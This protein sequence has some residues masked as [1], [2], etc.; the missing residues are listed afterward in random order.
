MRCGQIVGLE[1]L[2]LESQF[3]LSLVPDGAPGRTRTPDPLIRRHWRAT[4]RVPAMPWPY[5]IVSRH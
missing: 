5:W 3:P 4:W 2:R 1:G